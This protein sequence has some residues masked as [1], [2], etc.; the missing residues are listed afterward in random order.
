[1]ENFY[2]KRGLNNDMLYVTF[3]IAEIFPQYGRFFN[4]KVY[5]LR[6]ISQMRWAQ[7]SLEA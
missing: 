4:L 7:P 3:N 1:M 2:I 5:L 6:N